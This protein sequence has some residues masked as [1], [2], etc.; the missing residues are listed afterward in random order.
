MRVS[1]KDV[2]A[3]VIA[4]VVR[5]EDGAYVH[6]IDALYVPVYS[7]LRRLT[8]RSDIAEDLTQETFVAAWQGIGSFRR[9]SRFSSWVFGIAYRQYLRYRDSCSPESMPLDEYVDREDRSP[10]GNPYDAEDERLRLR[11]AVDALP[12][13][14]AEVVSLVHVNGLSYRE[15]AHVLSLPIGTIK[16]RMNYAFKLLREILGES[17]V[18]DHEVQEPECPSP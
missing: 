9:E 18:Q 7:F 11:A 3:K 15:T 12:A 13:L 16:S 10:I 5:G 14:Y 1:M 17:E 6:V 2:A 4:A 8:R